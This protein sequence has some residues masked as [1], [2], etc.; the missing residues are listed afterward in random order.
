MIPN[1]FNTLR[2]FV[3]DSRLLRYIATPWIPLNTV[4][5]TLPYYT[6][7][8]IT[9][10]VPDHTIHDCREK[11]C[12]FRH[13][14]LH[15][16]PPRMYTST[17]DIN[18]TGRFG[19]VGWLGEQ[20]QRYGRLVSFQRYIGIFMHVKLARDYSAL[21]SSRKV[22]KTVHALSAAGQWI[23]NYVRPL[24]VHKLGPPVSVTC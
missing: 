4:P 2:L 21:I 5:S 3:I 18:K 20:Y 17:G 24:F 12:V 13:E 16:T 11:M 9:E 1:C 23:V 14:S 22:G 19:V 8:N 10:V 6:S 7:L 15:S